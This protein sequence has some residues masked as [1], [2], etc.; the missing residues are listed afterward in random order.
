MKTSFNKRISIASC[1]AASRIALLDKVERYEDSYAINQEFCEWITCLN[2]YPEGIKASSLRVPDF[3][4]ESY[5]AD[6]LLEL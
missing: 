6:E 4:K 5:D 2:T 1:W 3:Q